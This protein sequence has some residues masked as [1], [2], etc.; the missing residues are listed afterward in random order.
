MW[1]KLG[2]VVKI[3]ISDLLWSDP[4]EEGNET[5][6]EESNDSETEDT[7]QTAVTTYFAYNHTRQCSFVYG[8]FIY[9]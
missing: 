3:Y 5:L 8:Y 2:F 7:P 4:I 1:Y 6:M 9:F